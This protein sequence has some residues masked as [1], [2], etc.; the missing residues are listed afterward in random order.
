MLVSFFFNAAHPD[1][2]KY[3]IGYRFDTPEGVTYEVTSPPTLRERAMRVEARP[4]A[5]FRRAA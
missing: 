1:L 2:D 5:V 4:V 3:V